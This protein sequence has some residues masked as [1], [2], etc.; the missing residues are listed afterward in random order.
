MLIL[1]VLLLSGYMALF[2]AMF[3]S[4]T[5]RIGLWFAPL[6]WMGVELLHELTDLAFPWGY[7]GY[8][9]TP[10]PLFTQTASLWGVYG[11]GAIIILINLG[12]YGAISRWRQKKK[13]IAWLLLTG[14]VL[15]FITG[16]GALR[17]ATAPKTDS[18]RVALIQPNIPIVMKG[19]EARRDS[20]IT[21]M[22]EQTKDAA[23]YKPDIILFPETATLAYLADY[24]SKYAK[25]YFKLADSLNLTLAT[26][27]P[28][29]IND[30]RSY[31]FA[32]AA[33][34]IH[35]SGYLDEIYIK[36]R[37][38]PF[39]E[40]IPFENIFPFLA[41]IDV[42]GGHH[43]RGKKYTVYTTTPEPLSFLICYEA[44]FPQLTRN[45]VHRGSKLLCNITNDVWFGP[46]KG[47]LQHSEMAVLRTVENGV[48][49]IR[50]ANNG[51]SMIVDAYG[52]ILAKS[53]LLVKT[54]VYGKVPKASGR[55]TIYNLFG[56]LLPYLATGFVAIM[57][58]LRKI[59]RGKRGKRLGKKK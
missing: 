42:Q 41:K 1:G 13:R 54:T 43:Y 5:K 7:L 6:V 59:Q 29:M 27:M 30:G 38:A 3:A 19:L 47:P 53:K 9:M 12:L 58:L 16:F 24:D 48:P 26:G 52:R 22:I 4:F 34:V 50:A 35:P 20:L 25:R 56:F 33:T 44:I 18:L 55:K 17:L 2:P 46:A 32:N 8:T 45:F 10:W 36:M 37:L 15:V 31:R 40:T 21:A 23:S 49:M 14:S 51:V 39:G 28:H 11:L 57:L